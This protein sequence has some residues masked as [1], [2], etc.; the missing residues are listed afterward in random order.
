MEQSSINYKISY[1]Q[2]GAD[3]FLILILALHMQYNIHSEVY[4]VTVTHLAY[5]LAQIDAN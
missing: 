5:T 3:Q 4:V 1:L 2:K